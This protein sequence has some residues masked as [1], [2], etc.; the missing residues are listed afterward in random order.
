MFRTLLRT[1]YL[2]SSSPGHR[3]RVKALLATPSDGNKNLYRP[4]RG[5]D[6]YPR[7][8]KINQAKPSKVWA[9]IPWADEFL[10]QAHMFHFIS[11]EPVEVRSGVDL[12]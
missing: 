2:K 11:L 4:L 10:M 8:A 12:E 7:P 6:W 9:K 5:C 1:A 3:T